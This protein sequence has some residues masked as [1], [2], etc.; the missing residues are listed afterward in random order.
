MKYWLRDLDLADFI[1]DIEQ[2]LKAL[3]IL[4]ADFLDLCL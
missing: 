1:M 4:I 3:E 2:D